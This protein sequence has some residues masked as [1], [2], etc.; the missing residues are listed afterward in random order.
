MALQNC[1]L[2]VLQPVTPSAFSPSSF[3]IS[4]LNLLMSWSLNFPAFQLSIC[5][6]PETLCSSCLDLL[7]GRM[8]TYLTPLHLH[9]QVFANLSR[10]TRYPTPNCFGPLFYLMQVTLLN[11]QNAAGDESMEILKLA[12][13]N[14]H[15]QVRGCYTTGALQMCPGLSPYQY[16][17]QPYHLLDSVLSVCHRH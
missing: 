7:A 12:Y 15:F 1:I 10:I 5:H 6:I 8:F 9:T 4:R 14:C 3:L 16:L 17:S 2:V 13:L 11:S